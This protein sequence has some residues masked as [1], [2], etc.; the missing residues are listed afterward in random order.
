MRTPLAL[1]FSAFAAGCIV[2]TGVLTW[3]IYATSPK[4]IKWDTEKRVYMPD[5]EYAR[6]LAN[7]HREHMAQ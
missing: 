4:P 2:A 5:G 1:T 3:V 6:I 7:A